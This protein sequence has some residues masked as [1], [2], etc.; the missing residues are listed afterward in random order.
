MK[1]KDYLSKK[2]KAS[3]GRTNDWLAFCT[4][5]VTSGSLWA[6][7]PHVADADDGWIT[8]VPR[9]RYVVEGVG[10]AEGRN[11]FVSRLRVRLQGAKN[12]TTGKELGKTGTDSAMIGVCD[13]KAF[14]RA[15]ARASEDEVQGAIDAQTEDGFGVVRLRKF[16]GAVMPFVPTGSDGTGPVHALVSGG[17]RV[18]I[19]L[20]FAGEEDGSG[21]HDAISLLG[22][23]QD[24]FITRRM[25]DGTE[26][27]FWLGGELKA[28]KKFHIWSD[29]ASGP[30]EYRIRRSG[31]RPVTKW[32]PLQR[33]HVTATLGVGAYEIG[34]R[35]GKHTYSAI[36]VGLQ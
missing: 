13:I 21:R 20:S 19:E 14:D 17:K 11:R 36:K 31:G 26:A 3:K 2:G 8:K 22:H 16:P 25:A 5:D 6:G 10:R 29:A 35:I 32:L 33:K 4:F 34:F 27:S 18:G 30:I 9:G 15:C 12:A 1:L 7:D 24:T 28:G 23:D